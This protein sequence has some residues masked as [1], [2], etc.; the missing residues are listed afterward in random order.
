MRKTPL[1]PTLLASALVM[2]ALPACSATFTGTVTNKTSSRPSAG[3]TVALVDVQAGMSDV[4]TAKTNTAGQYSLDGP[5][6]GPYLIRVT[7]QGA[8]YFIAAPQS[9][10]GGDVTVY[11][12]AAS[13]PGVGIDANM[14]L[15]EAGGSTLRVHERFLIHNTSLPPRAQYSDNTFEIALPPDAELDGASAT[16]PGGLGTNT[17]LVPLSQKGHYTF[18]VPIQPDQGE[19]E[20]LFEV[21][22][23][24]P[25][26]GH[27]TFEPILLMPAD[28]LV[29]YIVS[30]MQFSKPEG[31]SFQSTQEDPRV[32]TYVTRN[33][34]PGQ[35]IRFTI[36]GEGQMQSSSPAGSMGMS[37]GSDAASSAAAGGA[38][39]GG[40]GAPINTPDPLSRYK[41]WI[42]A[43]LA[44]ILAGAAAFFLRRQ[45]S[46]ALLPAEDADSN[47][48]A[49]SPMPPHR[50]AAL[51]AGAPSRPASAGLLLN[52][53]KEELFA[54]ESD[55]LTGK[56]SAAEYA[57]TKAGLEALL[58]RELQKN[59]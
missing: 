53:I 54:L 23:H 21:D 45:A 17:R 38:P 49:S 29:V 41:W 59:Q 56:I 5:G 36:S 35:P 4:A 58:K 7:H 25:Y 37:S 32:Q 11:D 43:A 1:F 18:N 28:H 40:I 10:S 33:A 50:S 14:F 6:M 24:L 48:P 12:T 47:A 20:T 42:L 16:R 52:S 27:A 51:H 13:V 19:K 30:G 26:S 31:A 9:G 57:E 34:K 3:D 15:F 8:T 44:L 46:G 55:K 2:F 39:G 22:Y